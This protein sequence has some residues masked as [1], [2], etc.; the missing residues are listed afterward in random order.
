MQSASDVP[1]DLSRHTVLIAEDDRL[2]RRYLEAQLAP[3]G[4][5]VLQA[6]T[7]TETLECVKAQ[8]PDLVLLDIVMPGMDGF[9]VCRRI[10]ADPA[11]RDVVV[12]HLTAMQRDAKDR[13]FES[14]ADDFLN[15]P[16]HVVE[17]RTRVRHH[18]LLRQAQGQAA[19]ETAGEP[20]RWEEGRPARV[21]VLA[22]HP[23]LLDH[24]GAE[25]AAMGH[26]VQKADSIQGALPLISTS[27]AD[28]VV[29]DHH[30]SDGNA[31]QLAGMLRGV[32]RTR[33]LPILMVCARQNLEQEIRE[34]DT[35]PTDFLTKPF[36]PAELRM[37]V[38]QMLRH[39]QAQPMLEARRHFRDGLTGA[40]TGAFLEAHLE[41]LLQVAP[42]ARLPLALVALRPIREEGH[43]A[44]IL[45]ALARDMALLK[46]LSRPVDLIAR[47]SDQTFLILMPGFNQQELEH[48]QEAL[49]RAGF[50]GNR[51]GTMA[52]S[53]QTA[54]QLLEALST[55][56][57]E[58][59]DGTRP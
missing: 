45:E 1:T 37:R 10:K 53:G 42:L 46:G 43:W 17:L 7:G 26:D 8:H 32:R 15:K 57:R 34:G 54:R 48:W 23:N 25:I 52:Q 27:M 51:V 19:P 5:K 44:R 41:L 13:S 29:M 4:L 12:V 30:L 35:G 21:L 40:Y 55:R 14:G 50:R 9:E 16:P 39:T 49:V 2:M 36:L 33:D 22:S 59:E 24:M 11:T 20:L 31:I 47:A 38:G 56:L 18:L 28:L 3:L 6:S 58:A